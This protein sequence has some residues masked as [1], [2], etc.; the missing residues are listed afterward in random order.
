MNRPQR[1]QDLIGLLNRLYPPVLAEDWDNVGMQVGDPQAA[2]ERVLIALDPSEHALQKAREIGAQALVTHHPLI[3]KPLKRLS[4]DD[5]TGRTV[6]SAVN[7]Q[8]AII[9]AHTNLDTAP[10][11]LNHWLADR[12]GLEGTLPLIARS[13]DFLKL[14]VFVPG[15]HIE[16]VSEALFSAGAGQV[17]AYDRCSFR[18]HGVGTFRPGT[19]T[20]PF[21]GTIGQTELAEEIRLE[22]ILPKR[23]LRKC[24]EKMHLA[25]PYEEVAYDLIPLDNQMPDA[26]LGRIGKLPN[27]VAVD[28]FAAKVKA[29]LDCSHLRLVGSG[30]KE[31]RKV[32]VCGGSGASLV[33]AA[34]QQ[35]ADLLVTGDVKYHE[36]RIAEELGIALIDA[37]HFATERLMIEGVA[38]NLRCAAQNKHWQIEFVVY[39]EET[40]PFRII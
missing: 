29:L 40:D 19:G 37:G 17:G 15:D 38:K 32:A 27:P 11:G 36:A 13:G 25:H 35:G 24:L 1:I 14:V 31:I 34:C 2:V 28:Q 5:T 12:L 20:N 10:A 22:T 21:S 33:T 39:T 26:G 18:T 4:P 9:C 8:V 30:K 6:W 16:A 7:G 23:Q 3:F